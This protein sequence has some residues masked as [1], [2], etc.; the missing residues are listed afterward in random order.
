MWTLDAAHVVHLE[1]RV[2]ALV[3]VGERG[4]KWLPPPHLPAFADGCAQP[5]DRGQP[6]ADRPGQPADR[7]VEARLDLGEVDDRL[8]HPRLRRVACRVAGGEGTPG[9]VHDGAGD[10]PHRSGAGHG[11]VNAPARRV[12][13]SHQLG[14]AV[15]AEHRTSARTQ[16]HRP[17]EARARQRARESGVDPGEHGLPSPAAE[18][19]P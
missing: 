3:D 10:G 12:G 11:H 15:V 18:P 4:Q 17:H 16:Q 14:R 9:A 7:V 2:T 13:Q 5:L 8:L 1:E 6:R 19:G